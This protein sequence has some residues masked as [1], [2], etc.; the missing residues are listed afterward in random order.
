ML[1]SG[2]S[3]I[4]ASINSTEEIRALTVANTMVSQMPSVQ[5]NKVV[6]ELLELYPD[7]PALGSPFDTG[8][9]TFGLSSQFKR[10][11]ALLGDVSFQSQRRA[12]IQAAS[13]RGVKTFGYLFTDNA[14]VAFPLLGGSPELG[15]T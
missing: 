3:F 10:A 13:S 15:G 11:A 6:D 4:P 1:P 12:W 14:P 8:N 7:I 5:L 9:E 2:T